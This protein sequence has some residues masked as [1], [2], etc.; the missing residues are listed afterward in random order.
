MENLITLLVCV[1]KRVGWFQLIC[2]VSEPSI[3]PQGCLI[4]YTT[5]HNNY[6]TIRLEFKI[7]ASQ[8]LLMFVWRIFLKW[9]VEQRHPLLF[10]FRIIFRNTSTGIWAG[11]TSPS[12]QPLHA[13][14]MCSRQIHLE[15][16]QCK[17]SLRKFHRSLNRQT[18]HTCQE[19]WLYFFRFNLQ[20]LYILD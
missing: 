8:D 10:Q 11:K 4:F 17:F 7:G 6:S 18:N 20:V 19:D 16:S 5:G 12:Y 2:L 1:T 15:C 9:V 14:T 3:S 13:T